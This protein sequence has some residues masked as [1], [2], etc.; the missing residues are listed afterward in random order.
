MSQLEA[1]IIVVELGG[2]DHPVTTKE[3]KAK[4]L[5]KFPDL[6]LHT[7]VGIRLARLRANGYIKGTPKGWTVVDDSLIDRMN[8]RQI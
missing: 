5:E 2:R 6:A 3:V 8:R 7:Y 1:L 4:A